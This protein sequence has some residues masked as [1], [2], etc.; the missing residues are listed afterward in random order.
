[1]QPLHFYSYEGL[2]ESSAIFSD[3]P[4]GVSSE[5]QLSVEL[6]P[7]SRT[8]ASSFQAEVRRLPAFGSFSSERT[9]GLEKSNS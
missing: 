1:V 4:C 3:G 8:D 6:G 5:L 9:H 2:I 7:R